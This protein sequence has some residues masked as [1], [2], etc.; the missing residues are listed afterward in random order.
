M[1]L[2]PSSEAS[3]CEA[4]E[5]FHNILWNTKIHD[6]FIRTHHQFLSWGLSIQSLNTIISP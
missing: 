6:Q 3:R 4:N 2:N 5:E 1:E